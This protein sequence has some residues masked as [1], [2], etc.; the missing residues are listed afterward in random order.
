MLLTG[1]LR[2][3]ISFRMPRPKAHWRT[4]RNSGRLKDSAPDFHTTKP[5]KDNLE[6]ALVDALGAFDSC[7]SLLWVDDAQIADGRISKR[8]VRAGEEP[9]ATVAIWELA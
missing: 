9:G 5:D 3:D 6:K 2:V 8:Y 1:P 7:P 4:G